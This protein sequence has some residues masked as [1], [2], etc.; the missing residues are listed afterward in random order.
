MTVYLALCPN[1]SAMYRHANGSKESLRSTVANLSGTELTITL[2]QREAIIYVSAVHL[3][4]LQAVLLA[5]ESLGADS[6]LE[7]E[8]AA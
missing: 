7:G 8:G 2:A 6:K 4:D 1:H 3:L 5:E